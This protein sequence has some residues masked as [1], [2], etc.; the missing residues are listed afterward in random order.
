MKKFLLILLAPF[1]MFSCNSLGIRG[2][3]KS[4]IT[5][6][7]AVK[8][9]ELMDQSDNPA[10]KYLILQKLKDTLI[11]INNV[12]A[13]DIRES[14]NIDYNFCVVVSVPYAKGEV[15]CYIY[16]KDFYL[17][18]DI[19]TVSKLVKGKTRI[20]VIGEFNR[21]FTLLDETYAKIEIENA[22][23]TIKEDK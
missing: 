8:Q 3:Y 16:A 1:F 7:E 17:K 20:D 22:S 6:I 5:V 15:E 19:E 14:G 18:E 9:K 11:I 21:F 4:E 12:T 10:F 13:K 2:I 23:I